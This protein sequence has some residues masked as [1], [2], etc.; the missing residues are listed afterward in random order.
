MILK[1]SHRESNV[2]IHGWKTISMKTDAAKGYLYVIAAALMWASCGTVGKALFQAGMTPLELVRIR[3]TF[4]S[5]ILALVFGL[6][7][8]YLFQIRPRDILNF[9]VLGGVVMALVQFSY[10]AAISKIH[11]AAAI[12]LQYLAPIIVAVYSMCFWNERVSAIKLSALVLAVA[13]CYL[14][15]GGYS[16]HLLTMN[17]IGILWGL[18]SA[19]AFASYT[20]L[21]ERVMH[22]YP[23]WTVIFYAMLCASISINAVGAPPQYLHMEYSMMQFLSLSYIVVMGTILPFGLYFIGVNYIRSTRTMITATL[24]P[25]SAAVMAFFLLGERLEVWQIIGGIAVVAAI[26]LL[27][28]QREQDELSPELIRK[29]SAETG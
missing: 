1:I 29:R 12:L 20:L 2:L 15:V 6:F 9:A 28:I 26:V 11:V 4:S 13:G 19:V 5:I 22:R 17:R 18:T 7:S 8:R 16:L 3:V 23:P 25:I 21:G 14:M 10:F 27:Q 24:E